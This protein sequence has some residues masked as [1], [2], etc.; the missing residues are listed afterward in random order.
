[1]GDYIDDLAAAALAGIPEPLWMST[2][3]ICSHVRNKP[4]SAENLAHV[5]RGNTALQAILASHT[6]YT[7]SKWLLM[8]EFAELDARRASVPMDGIEDDPDAYKCAAKSGL[9][10]LCLSGGGIRSATFNLG[11]L[12]GLAELGLLHCFDYLSSVSGGGYIHQWL[13]AWAS[14]EDFRTVAEK[15]VPLPDENCPKTHPEPLRWL[16]RYSNY[17]TP[18]LGIFSGDTWV[19]AATWVRNT[20]LNQ[21]ILACSL[22]AVVLIPHLLLK[23]RLHAGPAAAVAFGVLFAMLIAA[24]WYTGKNLSLCDLHT[25]SPSGVLGQTG[26]QLSVVAPMLLASVVAAMLFPMSVTTAFGLHLA[27]SFLIGWLLLMLFSLAV[28]FG[29]D[30]ILCYLQSRRGT[31]GVQGFWHFWKH[32]RKSKV[33]AVAL[34]PLASF[35]IAALV[36][37][38]AGAAWIAGSQYLLGRL[39]HLSPT[40]WYRLVLVLGPPLIVTGVLL[41]LVLLTGLLGRAYFNAR[42]EWLARLSGWAGFASLAWAV[43]IAITLLSHAVLVWSIP[44]VKTA[45]GLLLGWAGTTIGG[46]FAANGKGSS[47]ATDD[48]LPASSKVTE[49]LAVIAPYVFIVGLLILISL[50]AELV[51]LG[52]G[53]LWVVAAIAISAGVAVLLAWRVDVNEFSM[54][55]FYRDR[56]ARCY[57]G[58]SNRSRRPNPFT[59]FDDWDTKLPLDSLRSTRG[60]QGPFPIFC[61]ALNLTFGEDLA[62]QERKAA[63]FAFTSLYCGYDVPWTA[64]TAK[65]AALRFNGFVRTADYAYPQPGIHLPTAAA[66]SG[67]AV[68]PSMGYHSNPATAFLLTVFNVRLG[69]WLA[70]PRKLT[71]GGRM[72]H[73]PSWIPGRSGSNYPSSSPRSSLLYLI[74]ELMGQTD[75]TRRYVYLSDGGH[76]DNMG[77]YELVRRRCRYIVICDSEADA[78]LQ[79]EG[80]GMAIRKCRIDFGAEI[81]LD[82]RPLERSADTNN[83]NAHCVTGSIRYPEDAPDATPGT[84]VYIKS[85]LTGDE[86][87]DVL[88]YKKQDELFPQQSTADQWF[89]ESQFESYRRLG[90]HIAMAT[91]APA[92]PVAF[93]C[94]ERLGR[95]DYFSNL[96]KIWSAITPEMKEYSP[97]HSLRY[98]EL[99]E[100]TRTDSA[101]SG[102]F[103]LL[104]D[105]AAQ[106]IRHWRIA[107]TADE[108]AYAARFCLR[109]IEF[110]FTVYLQLRLMY[111]ENRA[112]PFTQGWLEIFHS[113][114]KIDVMQDAWRRYGAGY[115]RGFQLFMENPEVGFPKLTADAN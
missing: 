65:P 64:A 38:G 6:G 73:M 3:D 58:A 108:S 75:D 16:R 77:L 26:V 41:S 10:G 74:S 36:S 62:W 84:V 54:H 14:R 99:L 31:E 49:A 107:P 18:Q 67:A 39:W 102:L 83:S 103:D 37:S 32:T 35:V 44:H 20:L 109:F 76:F 94:R 100:Q 45:T 22:L 61:A 70:N 72:L 59:G 47:G 85:S 57:L 19:M 63:S 88:N 104:F 24:S 80:I 111:P 93:P 7:P 66:I 17:L 15:L 29:G 9:M 23:M 81:T 52:H 5:L 106:G 30:A 71:E 89:S 50:L 68:S 53:A 92:D 42:R 90:H 91:F 110:I 69:W 82:L 4:A 27:A 1:M 98:G 25:A 2:E 79:F 8:R 101:V 113:W 95:A 87:A 46:I 105:R 34:P 97:Q 60:Y 51:A 78:Q 11:I 56:L 115:T 12:Q 21:L 28:T 13:A 86:P 43:F 55:A 48:Q 96:N 114:G 40:S 33:M 112:H